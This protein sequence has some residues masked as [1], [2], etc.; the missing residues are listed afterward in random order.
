LDAADGTNNSRSHAR[1]QQFLEEVKN[2]PDEPGLV[3]IFSLP[4]TTSRS[5]KLESS[6]HHRLI[7]GHS[8]EECAQFFQVR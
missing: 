2:S 7:L 3:P 8:T 1:M 4:T 6:L 5:V